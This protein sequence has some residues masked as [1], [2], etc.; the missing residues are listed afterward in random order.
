LLILIELTL[1]PLAFKSILILSEGT[2]VAGV[3]GGFEFLLK[4]F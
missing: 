2:G 1:L 3:P 4:R